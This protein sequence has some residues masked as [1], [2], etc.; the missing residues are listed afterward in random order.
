MSAT[1]IGE[2]LRAWRV[3]RQLSQLQLSSR[4]DVSTRHL[5]YVE[6]G[7]STPTRQM[8]ERL[9]H[10]LEVPLRERNH[11]MLA[12]GLAP[13][14]PERGLDA[15]ELLAV[16]R[17]LQSLLEAHMPF[18]AL[19]LDRWWDIVDR[20]AAT[21]LLLAGCAAHLL[22][23]PMNAVRLTLH[24]EGLAPWIANLGQWRSRLLAQVRARFDRDGDVRLR[25]L[26]VEAAAYPGDGAGRLAPSDVVMP[27]ELTI[28]GAMLRFFSIS[29]TVESARDVTVDELRIEAFYP[30]DDATRS[31]VFALT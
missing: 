5:S 22:E 27:L 11:L 31:A 20:N 8:I 18:P 10:H 3:R 14:H 4:A 26:A 23:P 12:A 17:A 16:S 7:R 2:L 29:A 25:D 21:D 13:T 28:D 1:P 24:P 6:T 9:A 30:S 15:P 19:V